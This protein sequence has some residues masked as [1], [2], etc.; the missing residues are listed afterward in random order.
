[1]EDH[2]KLLLFSS[3]LCWVDKAFEAY[4]LVNTIIVCFNW[5]RHHTT[6]V[7]NLIL[8]IF[9]HWLRLYNGLRK[10]DD[11]IKLVVKEILQLTLLFL[12]VLV[13]DVA[14]KCD[15]TSVVSDSKENSFIK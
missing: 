14:F 1:M 2:L 15:Q 9:W 13:V 8:L 7:D 6:L 3:S 5:G 4:V 12:R 11:S 10:D